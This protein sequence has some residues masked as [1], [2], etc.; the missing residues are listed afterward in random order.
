M[1]TKILLLVSVFFAFV[2][3]A[4]AQS[5]EAR[6][7]EEITEFCDE[8]L[9]YQIDSFLIELQK[10]PSSKGYVVFYNADS[11]NGCQEKLQTKR[12]QFSGVINMIE[13]K[14]R[15]RGFDPKRFVW[16]N[17]GYKQNW[18]IELWI[19]PTETNAKARKIEEFGELN[20]ETSWQNI[21]FWLTEL[22][23]NPAAIGYAFYYGGKTYTERIYNEKTLT[24]QKALALLP[25]R[26]ELSPRIRALQ[27]HVRFR[28]F[29]KRVRFINGGYREKHTVELWFVPFGSDV[30]KPAPTLEEKDVKFRKGKAP[31]NVCYGIG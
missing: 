27:R 15:A 13:K 12:G 3:P 26:N 29:E 18:T 28:G 8:N 20:C 2:L 11:A 21:D 31:N 25:R 19:V 6:K 16:I 4:F 9:I 23:K 5:E 14:F 1:R 24:F 10:N 22:Q 7:I 17:G 30:P